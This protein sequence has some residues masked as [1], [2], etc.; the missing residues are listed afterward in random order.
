[1]YT[2]KTKSTK[3][4][5]DSFVLA[6][7]IAQLSGDATVTRPGLWLHIGRFGASTTKSRSYDLHQLNPLY[8]AI[9]SVLCATH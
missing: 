6:V 5:V 9:A 1:M 7:R 4:Q 8:V 3:T 2:I